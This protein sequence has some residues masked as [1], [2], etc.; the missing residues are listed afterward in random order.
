MAQYRYSRSMN[1]SLRILLMVLI[2]ALMELGVYFQGTSHIGY[3][4]AN[5]TAIALLI[6]V[7][8]LLR[9]HEWA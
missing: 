9:R 6:I 3:W 7:L 5:G 2:C 4:I 8:M 1:W